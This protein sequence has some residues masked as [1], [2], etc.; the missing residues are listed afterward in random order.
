[1]LTG[2][3]T[4]QRITSILTFSE[5][6]NKDRNDFLNRIVKVTWMLFV[7]VE[8]KEQS[9]QWMHT[10]SP[11]EPKYVSTNVC[12]KADGNCF[13]GQKRNINGGIHATRDHNNLR[14]ELRNTKNTA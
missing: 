13:L 14:S 11:K 3:H 12:Q 8:T 9:Q 4:T 6:Y 1:M 7:N 10:H 5:Q 2:A